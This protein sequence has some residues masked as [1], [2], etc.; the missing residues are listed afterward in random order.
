MF[1]QLNLP[2]CELCLQIQVSAEVMSLLAPGDPTSQA[3]R[4]KSMKFCGQI[5]IWYRHEN[6]IEM[7]SFCRTSFLQS[8]D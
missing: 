1:I 7:F 5:A 8:E 3:W 6:Q 2:L 4:Q